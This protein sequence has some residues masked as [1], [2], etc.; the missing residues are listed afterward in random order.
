MAVPFCPCAFPHRARCQQ[1]GFA[2]D[3]ERCVA[4]N[5]LL[6]RGEYSDILSLPF[7]ET[8][9]SDVR[10]RTGALAGSSCF[11]LFSCFALLACPP[12]PN[13]LGIRLCEAGGG[14]G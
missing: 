12:A 7:L 1:G 11:S 8:L 2:S 10:S 6:L 5:V 13:G 4:Y 9:R 3:R 14:D